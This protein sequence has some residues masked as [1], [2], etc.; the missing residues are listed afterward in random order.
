[1]VASAA[2]GDKWGLREDK[3]TGIAQD[4]GRR[5][6]V[7][8]G[9]YVSFEALGPRRTDNYHLRERERERRNDSV[10]RPHFLDRCLL[11]ELRGISVHCR[12]C[13]V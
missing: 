4:D 11:L 7:P 2:E 13:S 10:S 8:K 5:A 12:A 3:E 1:M 9:K 6:L